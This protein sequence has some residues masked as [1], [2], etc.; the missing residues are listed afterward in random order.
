MKVGDLVQLVLGKE[1]PE[2]PQAGIIIEMINSDHTLPPVCKVLWAPGIIDKE[3]TDE[4]EVINES[5]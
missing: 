5:G 4:L 2:E 3:W 1:F